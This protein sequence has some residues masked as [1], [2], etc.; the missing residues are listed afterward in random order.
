MQAAEQS[1]AGR[2]RL[3]ARPSDGN[4]DK[5]PTAPP[6]RVKHGSGAGLLGSANVTSVLTALFVLF[7]TLYCTKALDAQQ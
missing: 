7:A 1:G 2:A 3:R 6:S 5:Q 4:S